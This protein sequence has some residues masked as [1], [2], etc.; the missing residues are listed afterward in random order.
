M[1]TEGLHCDKNAKID[2]PHILV[3]DPLGNKKSLLNCS[4]SVFAMWDVEEYI[5]PGA[6]WFFDDFETE[7]SLIFV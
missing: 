7:L 2:A 6:V 3:P 5:A 4:Y 1:W